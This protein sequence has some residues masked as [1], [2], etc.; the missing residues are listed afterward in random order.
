M[1]EYQVCLLID[2]ESRSRSHS[3]LGQKKKDSACERLTVPAQVSV[4]DYHGDQA[5]LNYPSMPQQEGEVR[6]CSCV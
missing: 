1:Y 3:P 2:T 5:V 6:F 4:Q